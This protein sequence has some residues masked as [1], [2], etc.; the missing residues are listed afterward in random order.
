MTGHPK[1][2]YATILFYSVIFLALFFPSIIFAKPDQNPSFIV[3]D[4]NKV[5]DYR[6]LNFQLFDAS[7][8]GNVKSM[9]KLL[10]QGASVKARNRF[11][12][13]ALLRSKKWEA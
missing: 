5:P 10:K 8:E 7:K 12:N 6:Q 9:T 13:T 11:G 1:N 3:A 4:N 2:S